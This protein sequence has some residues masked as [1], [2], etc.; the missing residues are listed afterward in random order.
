M[1]QQN[2]VNNRDPALGKPVGKDQVGKA[3]VLLAKL[4]RGQEIRL[5]CKAYKVRQLR[6]TTLIAGN[7]QT[8][9][10]VVTTIDGCF[11]V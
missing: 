5:T 4:S 11:R 2:I 9:R 6:L 1:D 10:Q 8:P 3:P 7:C